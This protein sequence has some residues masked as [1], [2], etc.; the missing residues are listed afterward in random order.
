MIELQFMCTFIP[1][2]SFWNPKFCMRYSKSCSFESYIYRL[3]VTQVV[4][5]WAV[6]TSIL[7]HPSLNKQMQMT[8]NRGNKFMPA[9]LYM[10]S[11]KLER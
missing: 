3:S 1:H 8:Y 6:L 10:Q 5:L 11:K 4:L 7:I 2:C 9:Q